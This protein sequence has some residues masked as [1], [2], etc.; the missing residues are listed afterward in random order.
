MLSIK[1]LLYAAARG[2]EREGDKTEGERL[3]AMARR[4]QTVDQREY[5]RDR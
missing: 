4:A 1:A 2:A 5:W 3:R